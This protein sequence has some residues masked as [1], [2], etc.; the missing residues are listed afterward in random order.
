MQT[1]TERKHFKARQG[2]AG[3]ISIKIT[4]GMLH[5]VG[6]STKEKIYYF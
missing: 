6:N 2:M 5:F 1:V 3:C 4:V